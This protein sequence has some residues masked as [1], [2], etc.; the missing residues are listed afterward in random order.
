M[1]LN[2]LKSSI[3]RTCLALLL[4][5]VITSCGPTPSPL[6]I[7]ASPTP[8]PPQPTNAEPATTSDQASLLKTGLR[9]NDTS[10]DIAIPFLDVVAFQAAVNEETETLE[11]L[12]QMRDIP[13]TAT[14][15]QVK[16]LIEHNWL[17]YVYLDPSK[18]S[19]ADI[20]G[21]F[22]LGLNP[23]IED[24]SLLA[25]GNLTPI[26][27]EPSIVPFDQLWDHQTVYRGSGTNAAALDVIANVDLD[28]L[29]LRGRVPGIKST[30]GFSF[31]MSYYDGT[32]DRPD[33]M[34][35]ETTMFNTGLNYSDASGDMEVSFLDV[36]GFQATVN[37]ATETLEVVLQLRDIP[38]TATRR[39]IRNLTE[40]M[41][42]ISIFTDP[43]KL[44]IANAQA[45]YQLFLMT[46]VTDPPTVEGVMTPVPGEPETVPFDNFWDGKNVNDGQGNLLYEMEATADPVQDTITMRAR[47]PEIKSEAAFRFAT[48]YYDGTIDRPD[49]YIPPESATVST[50]LP[51]T[52][53]SSQVSTNIPAR[54]DPTKLTPAGTVKA[55][56]G[57]EHYA[58][59]V[60]TFE[61]LNDG[62][63]GDETLDVSLTLDGN[64]PT[65]ASAT[66][67]Y[68]NLLLPLALDTT[69]LSGQHTLKLTTADGLLNETYI[70]EVLPADQ[71]PANEVDASWLIHE[72]DCCVLHYISETA[73]ARDIDFIFDNFQQAAE[74]FATITGNEINPKLDVYIMDRIWGNGGFGG[75]GELVISYFDRYYGP[76][77]GNEGLQTLARHEFTHAAGVGLKTTG[78]G[79]DF[80]GEGLA[81]YVAGGHYKPE[82]LAERGAA[83]LDL[84]HY[85][86]ITQFIPQHELSYLYP[87]AMLTYIV[88][89]YGIEK[90]WEFLGTDDNPNDDQP[91]SLDAALQTTFGVSVP[92][93]DASFQAWLESKEPEEQL[94]DLRLTVEL[95]DLRRQYQETYS[96]P[97]YFILASVEDAVARAEYLPVVIREARA[98]ANIAVELLI[99]HAQQAI[100]EADYVRA[101]DLNNTLAEIVSTGEITDPLAKEYLDIVLALE[102]V[103]YETLSLDLQGDQ[104]TAEVT[105]EPP[106]VTSVELEKVNS[107]WQLKP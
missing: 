17:V 46:L 95:Q 91:G 47:I 37:E 44:G 75:N 12:L 101:E 51:E 68:M 74:E 6:P 43:A 86:P 90:M 30:A 61:I 79:V 34:P 42:E 31:N 67:N 104:A 13:P 77:I 21:D 71:R 36:T 72:I 97:P 27:G 48:I 105:M 33:N 54:D 59:D 20:P 96:P 9:Y 5:S 3:S 83:L 73:A 70:F 52:T 89:T 65:E 2:S 40:Y 38:E 78:N 35:D 76:T 81:V 66:S 87:A 100:V 32:Q 82:P 62:R 19:P 63:F 93:F 25:S 26:P 7:V 55:Y 57:P 103:G 39:Q 16:N 50:P 80:N 49:S 41:W 14:R 69:N 1:T 29:L 85:V 45:D 18:A 24:L 99:A 107:S 28:T 56:P 8:I 22:Y 11:V 23:D 15:G 94:E 92:E 53:Q 102:E 58:G 88:E 60:L 10:G 84:G 106:V 64:P 4:I 98:P